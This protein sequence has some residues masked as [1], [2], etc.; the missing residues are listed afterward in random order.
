MLLSVIV[1]SYNEAEILKRTLPELYAYLKTL[2]WDFELIVGNDGS[3]DA[4]ESTIKNFAKGKRNVRYVGYAQNR[5][6]GAILT[7]CFKTATGDIQLFI[8]ADLT[9]EK[10]LIPV[11]VGALKKGDISIASKHLRGAKVAYPLVR[12]ITSNGY[13]LLTRLLF[14]VPLKDF[15]CGLKAFK[16]EVI[17]DLLP[18][19]VNQRFLWDTE[20]LVKAFRKHYKIVEIPAV[21]HPAGRSSV[22]V[23]RDTFR[24]FRG[25][26][27]LRLNGPHQ[28][29]KR[30]QV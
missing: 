26:L 27:A 5:G 16:K 13:G 8:D 29:R 10:T 9:I 7:E 24:M 28:V 21:V 30:A 22:H 14:G 25:L 4:T 3:K 11:L 23:L 2:P 19:T 1:P 15:Q 18:G 20:I 12:R 17:R 6:K